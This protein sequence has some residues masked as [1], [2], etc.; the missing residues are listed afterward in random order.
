M[1]LGYGNYGIFLLTG[2]CRIYISNRKF[3]GP[4]ADRI[5]RAMNLDL[6]PVFLSPKPKVHAKAPWFSV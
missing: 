5:Q 1:A 2:K 6:C 3:Q 4:C